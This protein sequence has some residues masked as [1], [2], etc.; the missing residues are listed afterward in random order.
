MM[1]ITTSVLRMTLE[2]ISKGGSHGQK[3][4]KIEFPELNIK[5]H[6]TLEGI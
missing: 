1:I 5:C 3:Y 2:P 6:H 4:E